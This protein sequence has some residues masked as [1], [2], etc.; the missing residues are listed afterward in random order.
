MVIYTEMRA[1]PESIERHRKVLEI[2]VKHDA[3]PMMIETLLR[4]AED[5]LVEGEKTYALEFAVLV[6]CYP[7]KPPIRQR[8]EALL[9]RL[10]QQLD[11]EWIKAAK[12]LTDERTL[13]GV[14]ESLLNPS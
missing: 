3:V 13:E 11:P 6:L 10:E 9:Q 2:A 7:M 5:L 8:A 4:I 14:I 1:L 12:A